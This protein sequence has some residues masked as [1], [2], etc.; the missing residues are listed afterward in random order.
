MQ[1]LYTLGLC[2][3]FVGGVYFTAKFIT[4]LEKD[5]ESE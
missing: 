1:F 4:S 5:D 2:I 3:A